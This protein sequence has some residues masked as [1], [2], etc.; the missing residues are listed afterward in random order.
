MNQNLRWWQVLLFFAL[1]AG[2]IAYQV[3]RSGEL[4]ADD[5]RKELQDIQF[6]AC[7]C[8]SILGGADPACARKAASRLTS[9]VGSQEGREAFTEKLREVEADIVAVENCLAKHL[10]PEEV[11]NIRFEY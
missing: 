1:F 9:Y 7:G 10:P 6:E 3:M 4:R 8:G 5:I 11:P 2:V